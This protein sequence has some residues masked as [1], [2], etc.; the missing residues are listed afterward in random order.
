MLRCVSPVVT[1]D[2][3]AQGINVGDVFYT[4]TKSDG[5]V[6][7]VEP[8]GYVYRDLVRVSDGHRFTI[9]EEHLACFEEVE[10]FRDSYRDAM[11]EAYRSRE[12]R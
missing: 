10:G 6:T 8:G 1:K 2:R 9:R 11:S 3:R 4:F 5:V 7:H 12:T